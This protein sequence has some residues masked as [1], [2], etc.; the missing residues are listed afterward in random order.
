MTNPGRDVD[1]GRPGLVLAGLIAVLITLFGAGNPSASAAPGTQTQVRA[2]T[3]ETQVVVGTCDRVDAGQ[4]EGKR[5]PT[6]DSA[7]AAIVAVVNSLA[8]APMPALE[9]GYDGAVTRC[10]TSVRSFD[11]RT[12][13]QVDAVGSHTSAVSL[14]RPYGAVSHRPVVASGSGVAAKAETGLG[15]LTINVGKQDKHIP[16]TNNF[17]PGR[18]ELTTNPQQTTQPGR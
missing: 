18:S 8:T 9:H 15:R 1:R 6:G 17:I 3:P 14:R 12:V 16:G 7:L 10:D 4:R 11:G 2:H 5:P 13:V